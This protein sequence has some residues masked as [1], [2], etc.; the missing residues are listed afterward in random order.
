MAIAA[1]STIPAIQDKSLI[2]TT[3]TM[4]LEK[5]TLESLHQLSQQLNS[6]DTITVNPQTAADRL[7]LK[8]YGFQKSIQ[9]SNAATYQFFPARN[10]SIESISSIIYEDSKVT[11]YKPALLKALVDIA[12]GLNNEH[13]SFGSEGGIDYAYVPYGQVCYQWL[14]YYWPLFEQNIPQISKKRL[15]FEKSF[16]N[17]ISL[18]KDSY[19][20]SSLQQLLTEFKIGF[21]YQSPLQQQMKKVMFDIQRCI[22]QGPVTHAGSNT[23]STTASFNS[24]KKTKYCKLLDFIRHKKHIRVKLDL[25]F[26]MQVFGG[27]LS[28]AIAIKWAQ[29]SVRLSNGN[30]PD[31]T[32]QQVLP[33]ILEEEFES[34][35][36]QNA[37]SIANKYLKKHDHIECVYSG[38]ALTENTYDVDHILPYSIYYNNDL[39]NLVPADSKVNRKKSDK[40]L[41]IEALNSSKHRLEKYWEFASYTKPIHF[42]SELEATLRISTNE[43]SWRTKLFD[44]VVKQAETTAKHRGLP[45]WSI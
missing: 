24:K 12:A 31:I 39:W 6:G 7:L 14:K 11:T 8:T 43:S 22:E 25:F 15:G 5:I 10:Q 37:R 28:D 33:L 13:V 3:S 36:Q 1:A 44:S 16:R 18:A 32:L 9:L 27:I 21:P 19:G 35:D 41:T 42:T 23:F 29:E 38:R 4:Q 20:I 30:H 34:R 26:E 2:S 45:R 40:I 17:L